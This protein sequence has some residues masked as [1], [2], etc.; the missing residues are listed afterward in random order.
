[1][2]SLTSQPI[3][4]Y[5][6]VTNEGLVFEVKGV[7][8]PVDRLIAYLRYVPDPSGNRQSRDGLRFSKVYDLEKRNRYLREKHPQYL[9]YDEKRGR[10]LQAVPNDCVSYVLSPIDGLRQLRDLGLHMTALEEASQSLAQSIVDKAGIESSDIGLTGSQLVGLDTSQSD[11]DLVVYGAR[12]A[13]RVHA[14]LRDSSLPRTKRY[15]G[16]RLERHLD[17]RWKGH[18]R[19]RSVL[20]KIEA[21]KALQGLYDWID[22]FVRAVKL[23]DE[24]GYSYDDFTFECKG[25]RVV[26]CVVTNDSDSIFTP[27]TYL[28]QCEELPDLSRLVS[29][30][31]RFTEHVHRSERVEARGRLELVR[32]VTKAESFYQLVLGEDSFDYLVPVI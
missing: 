23:P 27:C 16:D 4:G 18:S 21:K 15:H 26:D 10:V 31:G 24:M 8:Q 3:E 13:K 5:F 9:W 6:V 32:N 12:Q 30:R 19:W 17:F 7:I 11:I 14:V 20:K 22:F 2:N 28:V 29:Y 1:M 25:T